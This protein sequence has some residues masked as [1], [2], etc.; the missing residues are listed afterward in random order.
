MLSGKVF[1]EATHEGRSTH[2]TINAVVAIG[3]LQ[4]R[5][6]F[7]LRT[8]HFA[9]DDRLRVSQLEARS[10]QL[11]AFPKDGPIT[12]LNRPDKNYRLAIVGRKSHN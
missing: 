12:V 1:R 4:L 3:V 7:A 8:F 5:G 2:R 10:Q 11:G 9:Q 6:K